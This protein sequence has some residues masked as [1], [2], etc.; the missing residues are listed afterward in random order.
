MSDRNTVLRAMHDLGLAAW[1]GGSMMGAAALNPA[2]EELPTQTDTARMAS[3]GWSKWTPINAVAIGIHLI[4]GAGLAMANRQR[5]GAQKG[6]LASTIGKTVLTCAALGATAY[7]RA[8]G[9][10]IEKASSPDS[11][12]AEKADPRSV[13]TA[14]RQLRIVKWTIPVLT[15]AIE[16]LNALHGEQQR[17]SQQVSG[18][19]RR[20]FSGLTPSVPSWPTWFPGEHRPAMRRMTRPC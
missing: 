8:L 3:S 13:G 12:K 15:G 11:E 10:K 4:G 14:Q 16:V 9:K 6:V 5:I 20:L 17:P 19:A 2:A 18:V 7:A 1:F